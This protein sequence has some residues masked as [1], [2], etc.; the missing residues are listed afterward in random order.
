[1]EMVNTNSNI[2]SRFCNIIHKNALKPLYKGKDKLYKHFW[3]V[4]NLQLG[5]IGPFWVSAAG[6]GMNAFWGQ[7]QYQYLQNQFVNTNTNT[8]NF[9]IFNTNTNTG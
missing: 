1:M 3:I 9:G 6:L 5:F 2:E 8:W 7:Y 4:W